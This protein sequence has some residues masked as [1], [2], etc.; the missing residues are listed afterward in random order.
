M[1]DPFVGGHVI[2]LIGELSAIAGKLNVASWN[3]SDPVLSKAFISTI[4][5]KIQTSDTLQQIAAM[6]ALAAFG[7]SSEKEL[8]LL[9][10]HKSIC[11]TWLRLGAS[12]KTDVKTNCFHSLARILARP[13]AI[14]NTMTTTTG[15]MNVPDPSA[16][17]WKLNAKLFEAFGAEC[18]HPN[19]GSV[20]YLMECLRQPFEEIRIGVFSLLRSV[21]AQNHE[22][23]VRA[24]LSYGG[25]FEFLMD[26]TTEPTK[27]TREWKFSIADVFLASKFQTV[28]G[29]SPLSFYLPQV[30]YSY[31]NDVC[32]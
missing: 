5:T 21:A 14:T 24:L 28:L 13:T 18:R 31:L 1:V 27:Q 4:E 7:S 30:L 17:I 16:D 11:R 6:D 19:G 2:R 12:T 23:G 3:W 15:S 8:Y 9:L 32:N 10:Q 26:R 22:W 29:K 25:F 20:Q